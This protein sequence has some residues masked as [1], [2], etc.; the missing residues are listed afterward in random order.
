MGGRRVSPPNY[1]LEHSM[2]VL[3]I[4]LSPYVRKV[5]VVLNIKGIDY[6]VQPVLPGSDD[7]DFRAVSPLGK[8]PVLID[9]DLSIPD[10]SVIC[11]YLEEA[12][13]E[14]PVLPRGPVDRARARF[15]EEYGDTK[16]VEVTAPVF[17]EN[18]VNPTIF[19]TGTDAARVEKVVNEALPPVL[20]YLEAVVPEADYLFGQ[21]C[22]ADVS[23]I[24]GTINA[25]YGGFE[26]DASR[27]PK[28]AAYQ[29][30]VME[31]PAVARAL[32]AE[33]LTM[34]AMQP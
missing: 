31:H 34:A 33:R 23:M 20:H 22:T 24:S 15:L 2:K 4:P 18:F 3:G 29:Q 8:I 30:R 19:K 11:E 25:G 1:F 6:E 13:P 27:W 14:I 32:E 10:S 5:A 28:Y 9:G 17:I 7:P 26:V 21:L 12:Y 16:L